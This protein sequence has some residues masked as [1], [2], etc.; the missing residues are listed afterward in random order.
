MQISLV[1][2]DDSGSYQA[3]LGQYIQ[4]EAA[5]AKAYADASAASAAQAA[6]VLSSSLKIANNLSD[7]ADV[8]TSRVNLSA[9]K[10]GANSDITSL[11]G[12]TTALSIAQG[13]TGANSASSARV[14]LGVPST[15][16]N[17]Y[18]GSQITAYNGPAINY[19]NDLSGTQSADI[20]FQSA[21]VTR[22]GIQKSSANNFNFQRFDASGT[23]VDNPLSFATATGVGT[24]TQ[25]PVFG[26][27]TP[28]DSSNLA[29]PATLGA[30]TFTA[31]QT[32]G[33]ANAAIILNDTAGNT[34]P[35][36]Q[37]QKAGVQQWQ[38]IGDNSAGLFSVSRY[39][40][41]GTFQDKPFQIAQA[42][43]TVTCTNMTV[44]GA[45]T[46]SQT[47]GIVG[48]TT[49][50]NAV[51]GAVGEYLEATQSTNVPL[52]NNV[53]TNV[54]SLSLTAGDWDV[55]GVVSV[56][57]SGANLGNTLGGVGTT[58]AAIPPLGQYWQSSV[59][60][61]TA[62]AHAVPTVRFSISAT[63]TVYL[64]GY[65]GFATGT[66]NATGK[67]RARRVR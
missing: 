21:T 6:A 54:T 51:A 12:L 58:S 47:A 5:S 67:I 11:S 56:A 16:S 64:I 2:T 59:A 46:P 40:T 30:N 26:S 22:W 41:A 27:A 35:Q 29:N 36:F 20:R 19:V 7:V 44:T 8:P 15:G 62:A 18:S 4:S 63:T 50:N 39:N 25:R 60:S 32:I 14:A 10:S 43:G 3:I 52:T 24:F 13:G 37:F 55:S 48:T 57:A 9:A 53:A 23:F 45:I 17:T 38:F 61:A 33:V 28:W 66:A 42:T 34:F 1:L 49:N 65:G 31:G